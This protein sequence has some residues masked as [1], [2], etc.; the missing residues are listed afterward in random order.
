MLTSA[1]GNTAGEDEGWRVYGID[2][3]TACV[4]RWE[5]RHKDIDAEKRAVRRGGGSGAWLGLAR[6]LPSPVAPGAE[7]LP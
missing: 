7:A 1:A 3:E 6:T 4:Q 2:G 5:R